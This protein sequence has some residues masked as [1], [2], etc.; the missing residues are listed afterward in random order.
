M[1][2]V[3]VVVN[4]VIIAVTSMNVTYLSLSMYLSVNRITLKVVEFFVKFLGRVDLK[5]WN[6]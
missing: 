4:F 6:N 2:L 1:R 5:I 3:L